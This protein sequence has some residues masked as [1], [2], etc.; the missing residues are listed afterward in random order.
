MIQSFISATIISPGIVIGGVAAVLGA[1]LLALGYLKAPPDTAFIISGLGK[2]RI[3]IGK[4]VALLY[5]SAIVRPTVV[6]ERD[7]RLAHV[8]L[9]YRRHGE[10]RR[11]LHRVRNR[12][13]RA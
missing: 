13:R 4:A 5:A 8:A 3:L 9:G 12:R 1:L 6:D 11:A 2:K 10:V 7:E